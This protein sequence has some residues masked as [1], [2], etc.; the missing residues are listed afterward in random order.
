MDENNGPG[1]QKHRYV[2]CIESRFA[3]CHGEFFLQKFFFEKYCILKITA[4]M[5]RYFKIAV[6]SISWKSNVAVHPKTVNNGRYHYFHPW[7]K[8]N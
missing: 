4:I 7:E 1:R 6:F 3:V 5:L 8:H 2:T